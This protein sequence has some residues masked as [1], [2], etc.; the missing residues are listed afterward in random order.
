MAI[1]IKMKRPGEQYSIYKNHGDAAVKA[2]EP[3]TAKPADAAKD[4]PSDSTAK[5][6]S[7]QPAPK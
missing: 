5:P 2:E 7:S 6:D 4:K 1:E 3:D